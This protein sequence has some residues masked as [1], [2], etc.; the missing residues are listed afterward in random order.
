MI[1]VMR[2]GASQ[3][4][5]AAVEAA[6]RETALEPH[7]IYGTERKVVAATGD[8][9]GVSPGTFELLSG[10]EKVMPVLAPYKLAS[11]ETR[12]GRTVVR[13]APRP[14]VGPFAAAW[15][16]REVVVIAGPCTVEGREQVVE[17]ARAV[18]AAGAVALRG[19]AFKPRT[20]PY[21]FQGLME[22]GLEYM[23]E[24]RAATGLPVVTEVLS[25]ADVKLVAGYADV[26]QIGARNMQNY[27]LL[28]AVGEINRPVY[29]I[30]YRS[31]TVAGNTP[32][33]PLF[34]DYEN[35]QWLPSV[36]PELGSGWVYIDNNGQLGGVVFPLLDRKLFM[37]VFVEYDPNEANYTRNSPRQMVATMRGTVYDTI[38]DDAY[39]APLSNVFGFGFSGDAGLLTWGVN[40]KLS[41]D[42]YSRKSDVAGVKSTLAN[43]T[44]RLDFTPSISMRGSAWRADLG[45]D[46]LYQWI[47][48]ETSTTGYVYPY[49]YSGN[50]EFSLYG[51]A[52]YEIT[53]YTTLV[54]GLSFGYAGA[55]DKLTGDRITL[56][57]TYLGLKFG[58]VVKPVERLTLGSNFLFYHT[59][60]G[61]V[62]KTAASKATRNGNLL[63]FNFTQTADFKV[64]DWFT[65]KAGIGK[66]IYVMTG[67]VKTTVPD[68]VNS[69]YDNNF[70]IGKFLGFS[71][72]Y[73]EL[74]MTALVNF[75]L[76]TRGPNFISGGGGWVDPMAFMATINY[77]W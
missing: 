32:I 38:G 68:V 36:I 11:V 40:L 52:M 13:P 49:D 14:G 76:I 18:R 70:D 5:L 67:E 7:V 1:I 61:L 8:E 6:V 54:G 4:E 9:R 10:V 37:Q 16:A 31:Y 25:A 57:N 23:A 64:C 58:V 74:T 28:R 62:E 2:P 35:A 72:L 69:S 26:L 56:D 45:L 60:G 34:V 15:G 20:N 48:N 55:A 51:R 71:I 59:W 66:D 17:T 63:L 41:A 42:Q 24:A 77:R 43:A 27:L 21:S 65:L 19:G 75:D 73:K 39:I 44:Y 47:S 22:E 12:P 50:A 29:E 3:E 53:K 33:L 30:G 46:F